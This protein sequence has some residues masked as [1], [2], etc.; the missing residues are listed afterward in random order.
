M[1]I[2]KVLSCQKFRAGVRMEILCGERALPLPLRQTY[3][4]AR[5]V[6]QQLSV[7]PL[8]AAAAVERLEAELTAAKQRVAQLEERCFST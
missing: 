6:G 3:D 5:A 1:G 2:I 4:Q 8:D 7:K